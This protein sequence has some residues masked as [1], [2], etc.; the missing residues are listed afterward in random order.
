MN[1]GPTHYESALEASIWPNNRWYSWLLRH[2]DTCSDSA[3]D[4]ECFLIVPTKQS[5]SVTLMVARTTIRRRSQ[6][7]PARI[8]ARGPLRFMSGPP[9]GRTFRTGE[10]Q[11]VSPRLPTQPGRHLT[12]GLLIQRRTYTYVSSRESGIFRNSYR[13][14]VTTISAGR[15][16]TCPISHG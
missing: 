16:R 7:S 1:P 14:V 15:N 10:R 6:A 2:W 3:F 5:C 8:P 9:M 11:E 12:R 13:A 4:V